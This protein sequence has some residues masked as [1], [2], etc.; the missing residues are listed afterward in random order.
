MKL[1]SFGKV[2]GKD[3]GKKSKSAGTM[4]RNVGKN[5]KCWHRNSLKILTH[6]GNE[7]QKAS[8]LFYAHWINKNEQLYL[9]ELFKLRYSVWLWQPLCYLF[10]WIKILCFSEGIFCKAEIMWKEEH[11]FILVLMTLNE[12]WNLWKTKHF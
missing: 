2:D 6:M 3:L 4:D 10:H 12:I 5:F 9:A 7:S 8:V 11:S 1:F